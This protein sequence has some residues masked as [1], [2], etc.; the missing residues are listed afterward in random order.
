MPKGV[1][2]RGPRGPYNKA[3]KGQMGPFQRRRRIGYWRYG[4][5]VQNIVHN[6]KRTCLIEDIA[7]TNVHKAYSFTL[8]QLPNVGEFTTLFD[9]YRIN[10]IVLTIEPAM[11]SNQMTS[12]QLISRKWLRVVHDYDDANVLANENQY[13]EYAN[14]KSYDC[15]KAAK[16]VLYPKIARQIFNGALTTAYGQEGKVWL[17]SASPDVPHYG[18]KMF[19][20]ALGID[21]SF[22]FR[23]RATYYI[24]CKQ[25]R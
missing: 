3:R 11:E 20:P 19:I 14:M 23:V 5:K 22:Q 24:S 13:F 25:T 21:N 9:T 4:P 8:S 10:K 12:P 16:I 2:L 6:F 7:L 1:Y 15:L 17:D 18:I